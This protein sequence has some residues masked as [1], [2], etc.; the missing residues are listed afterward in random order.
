MSA[1]PRQCLRLCLLAFLLLPAGGAARA[2]S[3]AVLE[4]D[5]ARRVELA[6]KMVKI[7]PV[8]GQVER[9]VDAYINHYMQGRAESER[10]LFRVAMLRAINAA[11]LEKVTVD[12]YAETFTEAELAAMTE[13][14]GSPEARSAAAKEAE[15]KKKIEPE[16]VRMLDQAL[17]KARTE[18]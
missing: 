14:Y 17:M 10:A 13:Y 11:A 5:L 8:R 6:E 2:E 12:A 18:P 15:L 9:A 3:G 4:A 16:L 7:R 1:T